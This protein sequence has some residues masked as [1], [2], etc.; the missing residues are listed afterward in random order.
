MLKMRQPEGAV[1]QKMARAG[2]SQAAI[3]AFIANPSAPAPAV[4][5]APVRPMGGP[6]FLAGIGAAKLKKVNTPAEKSLAP[7]PPKKTGAAAAAASIA[8][9][10]Q[11]KAQERAQRATMSVE[12][13]LAAAKAAREAEAATATKTG[14]GAFAAELKQRAAPKTAA[15]AAPIAKRQVL[16][17]NDAGP[18]PKGWKYVIDEDGDKYYVKSNGT[19]QWNRPSEGGKR[20]KS[21]RNARKNRKTRKN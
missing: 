12:E 20:R 21:R 3:N 14:F 16:N 10:A 11:R 5:A 1:R 13:R 19:S 17:A 8:E 6:A 18:L 7:E 2:I 4:E 9:E 15:P